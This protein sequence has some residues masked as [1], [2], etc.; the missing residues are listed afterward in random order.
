MAQSVAMA[1]FFGAYFVLRE[2]QHDTRQLARIQLW[3]ALFSN[4]IR[5]A[6]SAFARS[7]E[8]AADRFALEAT[9][10][11]RAGASAFRR[12]RDQNLAEDEQPAWFEFIF[13][14]HPSLKARIAALE[15]AYS[16]DLHRLTESFNRN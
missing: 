6:V 2:T 15:N 14:T 13:S 12:L 10:G 3:A 1:I 5:P 16:N 11:P 7:R 8:W 4:L 9:H